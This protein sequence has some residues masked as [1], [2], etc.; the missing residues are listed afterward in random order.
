[1]R[2][3]QIAIVSCAL[4][5][6][7]CSTSAATTSSPSPPPPT[8]PPDLRLIVLPDA[9]GGFPADR[10]LG[11]HSGP[12]FPASAL[13]STV[14]VSEPG[15]EFVVAAMDSFLSSGEGAFWPQDGWRILDQ[16]EDEMLVVHIDVAANP[17]DP[18]VAFMT[19]EKR[20]DE[21]RWGGSQSGSNCDLRTEMPEGLN[22]VDWRVDPT[23]VADPASAEVLLLVTEVECASGQAMGDRLLE[24]EVVITDDAVLIA[25]AAE[26]D[27]ADSHTCQGNPETPVTIVLSEPIEDRELRDGMVVM[28]SLVDFL[29][30]DFGS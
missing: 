8:P 17:D 4:L 12:F 3:I 30:E 21:W 24:P 9:A 11:C 29:A 20:D 16:T 22:R 7:A 27:D 6:G 15:F 13:D 26:P 14:A 18:P 25:F 19:V 10:R 2:R 23:W 28:G 1:M 5:A